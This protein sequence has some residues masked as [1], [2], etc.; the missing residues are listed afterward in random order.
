MDIEAVQNEKQNAWHE[1]SVEQ[2]IYGHGL[3]KK[4]KL[5][6][7]R[8]YMLANYYNPPDLSSGIR[9]GIFII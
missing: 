3:N 8:H 9:T 2:G 6:I 5:V 1:L 4:K 7:N